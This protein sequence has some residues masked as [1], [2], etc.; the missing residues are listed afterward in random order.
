[1]T[2]PLVG[3]LLD[4]NNAYSYSYTDILFVLIYIGTSGYYDLPFY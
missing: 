4:N 2:L 3:P 1:M